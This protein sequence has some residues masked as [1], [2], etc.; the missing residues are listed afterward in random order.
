MS[1]ARVTLRCEWC[2]ED[3]QRRE[4]QADSSRFCS[5]RCQGEW[6]SENRSGENSPHWEGGPDDPRNS[7]EWPEM[8]KE[9]LERDEYICQRCSA[10]ATPSPH[11]HHNVPVSE[12]GENNLENLVTLCEDCHCSIHSSSKGWA[13]LTD[14]E[15]EI[16]LN[17]GDDVTE[18]YYGVVVT[19]V[20]KKIKLVEDDLE[21]LE[22][23]ETL[24]DELREIVCNDE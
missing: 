6:Y 4:E 18:K 15:R 1:S 10:E 11:V 14:R 3:Y 5:R 20:R 13:L 16:L 21:A 2:G 23:H 19:R 7:K 9:V 24:A 12:G 22:E 17:D 8:R